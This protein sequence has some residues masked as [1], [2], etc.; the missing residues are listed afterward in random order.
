MDKREFDLMQMVQ[1]I[2]V[3][4]GLELQEVKRLLAICQLQVFGAGQPIYTVG[5]QSDDMIILLKG[6]L[7]VTGKEGH[8][9]G[10]IHSGA[11]TGE[12]GVF[13]GRPRS[14]NV[15]PS[16]DSTGLVIHRSDMDSLLKE[17]SQLESKVLR[18]LLGLLCDR[19]IDANLTLEGLAKTAQ[20]SDDQVEMTVEEE[21]TR[22]WEDPESDV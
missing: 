8:A 5:G 3:F 9:L 17:D 21:A 4:K 2:G 16:V 22:E 12:V 7:T 18:N 10:E 13:T 14:A 19:L 6:E 15:T 11:S 1:R 20:N